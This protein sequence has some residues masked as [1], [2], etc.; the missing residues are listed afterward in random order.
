L[1]CCH[2]EILCSASKINRNTKAKYKTYS[3]VALS[4]GMVL[5]GSS[6]EI[7]RTRGQIM[8]NSRTVHKTPPIPK[9]TLSIHPIRRVLVSRGVLLQQ[10]KRIGASGEERW[11]WNRAW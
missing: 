9:L 11:R 8:D 1:V 3:V 2:F 10:R 7:L 4:T 5:I 6:F